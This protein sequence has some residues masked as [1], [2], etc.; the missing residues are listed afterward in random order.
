MNLNW[1]HR[2]AVDN[3][4]DSSNSF[5]YEV[6]FSHNTFSYR[7]MTNRQLISNVIHNHSIV[8]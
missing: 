3:L 1:H 5:L 4:L 6:L 2:V 7:Q 8:G